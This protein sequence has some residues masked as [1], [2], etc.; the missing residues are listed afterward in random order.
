[1]AGDI[2]DLFGEQSSTYAAALWL[3]K[4]TQ[5]VVHLGGPPHLTVE[6]AEKALR[7]HTQHD[8]AF[9]RD[10]IGAD[11]YATTTYEK[12]VDVAVV[13]RIETFDVV[14]FAALPI[15]FLTAL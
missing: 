9:A 15:P 6:A 3:W 1:M 2:F 12:R 7:T 13:L 10:H 4:T 14:A 5:G 8:L 11:V